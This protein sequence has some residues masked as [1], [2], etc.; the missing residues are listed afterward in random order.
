MAASINEA[1]HFFVLQISEKGGQFL[2]FGR[3]LW[4]L[5]DQLWM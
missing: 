4:S 2:R 3:C 5:E 1:G